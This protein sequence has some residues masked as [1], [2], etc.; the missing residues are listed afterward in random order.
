MLTLLPLEAEE[1]RF[2]KITNCC[3]SIL[4]P[5]LRDFLPLVKNISMSSALKRSI[6]YRAGESMSSV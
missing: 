5:N 3:V 6:I 4:S 1:N 2:L